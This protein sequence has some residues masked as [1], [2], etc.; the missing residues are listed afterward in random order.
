MK[1]SWKIARI[2]G[3][4]VFVHAT[5]LILIA[6][7][8]ISYYSLHQSIEEA[9][10]GLIFV[11][12]IFVIIVLHELGHALAARRY[13]VETKDITLLPIGGVARLER[14]PEDPRQELV[15]ALAGPAVNLVLAVICALLILPTTKLAAPGNFALVGQTFLQ[16]LFWT[17][18]WLA[19]FN[20]IPAFPMD[21]GRVLRALLAMK[22]N[23]VRATNIAASVG[24]AAAFLF[25]LFGLFGGHPFL[26]FIALFVWLGA[27]QEASAVRMK[28]AIT[29][30]PVE[31]AMI[32]E[33]HSLR[34]EDNL[35]LA[36]QHLLAGFQQDFPVLQEDG[37]VGIL[38]RQDLLVALAQ[39]GETGIVGDFMRRDFQTAGPD[40]SLEIALPRLEGCDCRTLLV[41]SQSRLVGVLTTDNLGEYLMIHTAMT[42]RTGRPS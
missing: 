25:G 28:S 4:D 8:F 36:V 15:V 32:R 40:E 7:V 13:G 6:F 37:P 20:M 29:G 30:V 16:K 38:T 23:Y 41:M 42:A 19:V 11:L 39:K 9:V 27:E 10:E 17:N 22:M 35:A 12:A 14:I 26:M 31:R 3:I 33:F 1:W 5:F 21:G 24:Q 34:P 2:K 18:I